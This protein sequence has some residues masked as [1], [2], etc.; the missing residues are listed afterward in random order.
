[1]RTAASKSFKEL[2]SPP[3]DLLVM[4]E[5][6]V[7]EVLLLTTKYGMPHTNTQTHKHTNTGMNINP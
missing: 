6:K 3:G 5:K 1:M 4:I 7:V 2:Q